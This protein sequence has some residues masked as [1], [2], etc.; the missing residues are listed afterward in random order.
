MASVHDHEDDGS[1][2]SDM[3]EPTEENSGES[4][5]ASAETMTEPSLT[6]NQD[7]QDLS[8]P[9]LAPDL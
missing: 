4:G 6:T 8:P 2:G 5:D 3:G 9:D 1:E 7:D